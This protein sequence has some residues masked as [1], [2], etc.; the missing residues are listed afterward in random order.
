MTVLWPLEFDFGKVTDLK[1]ISNLQRSWVEVAKIVKMT[2]F[3]HLLASQNWFHAKF[4]WWMVV[5]FCLDFHTVKQF[6]EKRKEMHS[7]EMSLR[8]YVKSLLDNSE[9]IKLPFLRMWNM[10]IWQISALRKYIKTRF[11]TSECVKKA[12]FQLLEPPKLI[13]RKIGVIEKLWNFP[14][15]KCRSFVWIFAPWC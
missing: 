11:R 7:L 6:D 5:E 10:L 4:E 15:L 9:V 14:T 13:S 8:F 3:E 1:N 12:D 2:V